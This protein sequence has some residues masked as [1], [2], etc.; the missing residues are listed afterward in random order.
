MNAAKEVK[1]GIIASVLDL[2][3]ET[4]MPP[5]T[6]V[7]FF[8]GD[9][10]VMNAVPR[11]P[12]SARTQISPWAKGLTPNHQISQGA[13][14]RA[15]PRANTRTTTKRLRRSSPSFVAQPR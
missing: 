9:P 13:K 7:V 1:R 4:T 15:Q 2:A 14:D 12:A 5:E 3:G 11:C 8:V 10:L 6:H